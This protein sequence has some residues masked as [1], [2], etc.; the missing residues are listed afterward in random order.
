MALGIA[1]NTNCNYHMNRT[2]LIDSGSK[3]VFAH[4]LKFKF[5]QMLTVT[6]LSKSM[7]LCNVYVHFYT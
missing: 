4:Q 2:D 6:T 3:I 7:T 1:D 5:K